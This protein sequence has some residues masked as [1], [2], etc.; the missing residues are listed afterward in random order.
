[1]LS[2]RVFS[3]GFLVLQVPPPPAMRFQVSLCP[4]PRRSLR[5]HQ[6]LIL[7][8]PLEQRHLPV[9]ACPPPAPSPAAASPSARWAPGTGR[10][11]P[12]WCRRASGPGAGRGQGRRR[13]RAGRRPQ[14]SGGWCRLGR[15]GLVGRASVRADGAVGAGREVRCLAEAGVAP[16][17]CLSATAAVAGQSRRSCLASSSAAAS[18]QQLSHCG[19]S[20]T[21]LPGPGHRLNLHYS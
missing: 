21:P 13:D 15:P 19:D 6:G 20:A 16:W 10:S 14:E 7:S 2:P 18:C 8:L 9:L 12:S 4:I 3:H 1:M 5:S 11:P 17:A